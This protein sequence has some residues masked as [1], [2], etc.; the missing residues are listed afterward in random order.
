[1]CINAD[2]IKDLTLFKK[3]QLLKNKQIIILGFGK[4][5]KRTVDFAISKGYKIIEI[6]DNYPKLDEYKGIKVCKPHDMQDKNM[7][8]IIS[9]YIARVDDLLF[10]QARDFGYNNLLR[11]AELFVNED[12]SYDE[13]R[14]FINDIQRLKMKKMYGNKLNILE[15]P[16]V[17]IQITEKCS[18]RCKECANLMQY[19]T[20]PQNINEQEVLYD[21]HK[22]LTTVDCIEEFRVLGGEPFIC[23]NLYKYIEELKKYDNIGTIV[24]ITNGT[25]I[26]QGKNLECLKSEKVQVRISD[27]GK[28]S[29]NLTNIKELFR[30]EH[31]FYDIYSLDDWYKAGYIG[32]YSRTV[33]QN[34]DIFQECSVKWCIAIRNNKL[35][36]CPFIANAWALKAIPDS[37]IEYV[38]LK[39]EDKNILRNKI[40]EYL[41]KDIL[42]GCDYCCGRPIVG[43]Q[44]VPVAEQTNTPINYIKY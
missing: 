5:G 36:R 22:L 23:Q 41:D 6:W 43:S 2:Y 38:D 9:A 21:I 37:D 20:N 33:E 31:I 40:M 1:M 34:K 26:P 39:I 13:Y 44:R 17:E 12:L 29:R 8:I 42:L 30:K 14:E 24:I 11:F 25:I 4:K 16:N 28:S 35:F 19:Y 3:N 18:L 15:F 27:Y 10:Q 7:P 32:K